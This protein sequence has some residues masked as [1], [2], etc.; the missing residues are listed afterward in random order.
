MISGVSALFCN[1][2]T[3]RNFLFWPNDKIQ[4]LY[5]DLIYYLIATG[6][7]P[8][9]A[10]ILYQIHQEEHPASLPILHLSNKPKW[11][12]SRQI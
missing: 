10:L 4:G 2:Y 8:I 3:G 7:G 5:R 11:N 1:P 12:S 9:F 6:Y